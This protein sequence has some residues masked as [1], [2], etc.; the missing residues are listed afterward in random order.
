MSEGELA[1]LAKQAKEKALGLEEE[2]VGKIKQK[3]WVK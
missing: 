1:A 2:A 3:H